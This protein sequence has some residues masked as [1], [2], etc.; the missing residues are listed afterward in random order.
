MRSQNGSDIGREIGRSR[1]FL[2][3]RT[4]TQRK[5]TQRKQTQRQRE[6]AMRLQTARCDAV[7]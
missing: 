6:Q 4:A 7:G 3:L 5:Q 1:R 2:G